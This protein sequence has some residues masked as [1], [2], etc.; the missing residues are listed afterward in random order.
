[1]PRSP[2]FACSSILG[3]GLLREHLGDRFLHQ[4]LVLA[5]VIAQCVLAD[6]PPY[7]RLILRAVEAD[8]ERPFHV[9]LWSNSAHTSADS[10]HA[11]GA[12][13]GLLSQPAAVDDDQV[14]IRADVHL[15]EP[16]ALERIVDIADRCLGE[17]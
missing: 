2:G 13:G 5:A 11:P 1:M 3:P 6:S 10:A 9:L 7:E 4:L 12:I 15:A 16:L 14:R 17:D 8:D